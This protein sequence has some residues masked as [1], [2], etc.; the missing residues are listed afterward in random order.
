MSAP[1]HI[2]PDTTAGGGGPATRGRE[3]ATGAWSPTVTRIAPH[4][5]GAPEPERAGVANGAASLADPASRTPSLKSRAIKGTLIWGVAYVFMQ[6]LRLGGNVWLAALL[7][8]WTFGLVAIAR[9]IQQGLTMFTELG[10]RPALIQ[11]ARSD[12]DFVNTAWTLGLIRGGAIWLCASALAY[13]MALFYARDEL[14]TLV[15]LL[16]LTAVLAGMQSTRSVTMNR[17]LREGP[18]AAMEVGTAALSRAVMIAWAYA[19]P[20]PWAL[21]AGTIAGSLA[22][23]LISHTLL[24]GEINRIRLEKAA[25]RAIMKFGTWI[26]VGTMIAFLGQQLDKVMLGKLD[27]LNMLGVYTMALALCAIPREVLGTIAV[28]ILYPVMAE[29]AREAP[30]HYARR[31]ARIRSMILPLGMACILGVVFASPWFF[32]LLYR[33]SYHDAAWIAPLACAGVWVAILN[34]ST[35]KALLA[36]GKTRALAVAGLIRVVVTAA[37]CLAGYD[38]LGVAGFVLGVAAGALGEHASNLF[39]LSRCGLNLA[40]RDTLATLVLAALAMSGWFSFDT[41]AAVLP[42]TDAMFAS[43]ANTPSQALGWSTLLELALPDARGPILALVE[44]APAVLASLVFQAAITLAVLIPS[45]RQVLPMLR[46]AR[47]A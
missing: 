4:R 43:L 20:T 21:V 14:V 17:E 31:V 29:M 34:A 3:R 37:A 25:M 45:A 32:T 47:K 41:L 1:E 13:P 38:L 11:S 10:I 26:F 27:G 30:R 40:W 44:Q 16:S 6:V 35:N 39:T 22:T 42:G 36:L 9:A 18:R 28:K 8:P 24:P 23:V 7:A 46:K 2:D 15:P 33:E 5:A 19:S 12:D